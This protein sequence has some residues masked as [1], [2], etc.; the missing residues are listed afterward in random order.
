MTK[1]R[2]LLSGGVFDCDLISDGPT[3]ALCDAA[4][5]EA[6]SSR[7]EVMGAL[8]LQDMVEHALKNYAEYINCG[9]IKS[10]CIK[11]KSSE[12]IYV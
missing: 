11:G 4:G 8:K 1:I 10:M 12:K 3:Q 5:E 9:Y 7:S 2:G 6:S